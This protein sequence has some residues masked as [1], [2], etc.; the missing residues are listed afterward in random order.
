MP[1]RFQSQSNH[2]SIIRR[3]DARCQ[4]NP[5]KPEEE[6]EVGTART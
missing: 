3:L 1:R 5:E 2:S 4:K 6:E